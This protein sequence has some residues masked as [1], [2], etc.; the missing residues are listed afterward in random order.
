MCVFCFPVH[1][2]FFMVLMFFP[3]WQSVFH[4]LIFMCL[5]FICFISDTV[6]LMRLFLCL[7]L[8]SESIVR[9]PSPYTEAEEGCILCV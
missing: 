2:Y 3:A 1:F 4:F 9:K 7:P 8:D 6:T 5:Y